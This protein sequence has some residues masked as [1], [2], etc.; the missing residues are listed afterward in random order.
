MRAA[1]RR[2]PSDAPTAPLDANSPLKIRSRPTPKRTAG[3]KPTPA[4]PAKKAAPAKSAAPTKKAAPAKDAPDAGSPQ[5][6]AATGSAGSPSGKPPRRSATMFPT[7][8]ALTGSLPIP[9]EPGGRGPRRMDSLFSPP[10]SKDGKDSKPG[11]PATPAA[12]PAEPPAATPPAAGK[13]GPSKPFWAADAKTAERP[14]YPIAPPSGS[15][16]ARPSS[17]QA[18]KEKPATGLAAGARPAGKTKPTTA[19]GSNGS[20]STAELLP[21]GPEG[22]SKAS[23]PPSG[24][25]VTGPFPIVIPAETPPREQ[26]RLVIFSIAVV[27]V[28]GLVVAAFSL[29]DLG[30]SDNDLT[31]DQIGAALPTSGVGAIEPT[32]APTVKPTTAAADP[33]PT[34]AGPSTTASKPVTI[35]SIRAL[36][37]MGDGDEDSASSPLAVD[38]DLSTSWQSQTYRSPTFGG[39][40]RGVGLSMKLKRSA[41]LSSATIDINGVGGVVE[42]YSA[43][44][45]DVAGSTLLGRG[46]MKNGRVTVNVKDAKA[47]KY[48]ILWFTR[49]PSVGGSYKV[50]VSEVRLK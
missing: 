7:S 27:L 46:S 3:A 14:G 41:S 19:S 39:L 21:W 20:G 48:V 11:A 4:A 23:S 42:V 30:S 26:S 6:P 34:A 36:D 45:P 37:P 13:A 29:R 18:D 17:T 1:P 8:V 50:E 32:E 31:P 25:E 33:V 2:L 47:A 22:W 40:K 9:K 15:P 35:A 44:R 38:G 10:P 49:L 16:A 5:S 12:T 24:P 28:L 43:H